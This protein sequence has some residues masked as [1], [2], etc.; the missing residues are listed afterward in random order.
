MPGGINMVARHIV[1]NERVSFRSVRT[2]AFYA[3]RKLQLTCHH[4]LGRSSRT[5]SMHMSNQNSV[6]PRMLRRLLGRPGS[7]GRALVQHFLVGTFAA[8]LLGGG[9][10]LYDIAGLATLIANSERGGLAVFLLFFGL[11]TTVGPIAQ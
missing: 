3:F 8:L 11:V 7:I 2:C 9:V 6:F 4:P 5:V 1:G 10:L